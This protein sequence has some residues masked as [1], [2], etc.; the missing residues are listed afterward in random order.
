ML[1]TGPLLDFV[2]SWTFSAASCT[3]SGSSFRFPS[4]QTFKSCF[5]MMASSY[6]DCSNYVVA[7][8]IKNQH[9]EYKAGRPSWVWRSPFTQRSHV[10]CNA[11]P[12]CS[13]IWREHAT[14]EKDID[15]EAVTIL[16]TYIIYVSRYHIVVNLMLTVS[17][18]VSL[19]SAKLI[20]VSTSCLLRLKLSML[21]AYTVTHPTP[22]S[23]HHSS[24]SSNCNNP[25]SISCICLHDSAWTGS[26]T[27]TRPSQVNKS[28]TSM[29][30]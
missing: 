8:I 26:I 12:M 29:A 15:I 9:R 27:S 1:S 25:P 23:R 18:C 6:T 2:A 4:M 13:S 14:L 7:W 20:S 17:S 11:I 3:P 30:Y 28:S 24:A 21:K 19:V 16:T 10:I 5:L 22:N